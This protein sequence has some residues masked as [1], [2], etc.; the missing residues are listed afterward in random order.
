MI[1]C[2][3]WMPTR[4]NPKR[5]EMDKK[6]FTAQTNRKRLHF[7]FALRW[8]WI[9]ISISIRE[10]SLLSPH[11]SHLWRDPFHSNSNSAD[12]KWINFFHFMIQL[13]IWINLMMLYHSVVRRSIST[14]PISSS[15]PASSTSDISQNFPIFGTFWTDTFVLW[16]RNW[17]E[18]FSIFDNISICRIRYSQRNQC[19]LSM[20]MTPNYY[21]GIV[22]S[23]EILLAFGKRD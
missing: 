10:A 9:L 4:R 5:K 13:K 17:I 2:A 19:R 12:E 18:K 6:P 21:F 23:R 7:S 15:C 14:V 16:K 22:R 3:L 8:N 1:F 20:M 11:P